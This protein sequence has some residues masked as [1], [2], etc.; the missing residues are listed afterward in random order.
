M[1]T[2][3]RIFMNEEVETYVEREVEGKLLHV[4]ALGEGLSRLNL[5][6]DKI[7]DAQEIKE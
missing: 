3:P 6:E 4:N 7:H 5:F 2:G 1:V